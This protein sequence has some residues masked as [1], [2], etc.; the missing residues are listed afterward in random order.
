MCKLTQTIEVLRES[1]TEKEAEALAFA[2]EM[3]S[4][5]GSIDPIFWEKKFSKVGFKG[6]DIAGLVQLINNNFNPVPSFKA[7]SV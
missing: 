2:L 6:V 7:A 3:G 4:K 5:D 1:F